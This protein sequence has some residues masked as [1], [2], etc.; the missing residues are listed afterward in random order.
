MKISPFLLSF[1][2]ANYLQAQ[3][4][5]KV[6]QFNLGHLLPSD[7]VSFHIEYPEYERLSRKA[8]E[9]LRNSGFE[10]SKQVKFNINRGISR[11]ETIVDVSYT[12]V[13]KRGGAW[14]VIKQ[15]E[16][17]HTIHDHGIKSYMRPIVRAAY[18]TAKASR[19]AENSVLAT[20]KWVKIRVSK[21]GIYQITDA[22]LKKA[23]FSNP[24]KVKL[25]GYGGRLIN[26]N[27]T[28]TGKNALIDDLN[29]VPLYRR[30]GSLLFYA[31][32]LITW[33]SNTKFTR[34]TF[35]NYSYYFL[36]EAEDDTLPAT[37]QIAEATSAE[38][39]KEVTAV[40]YHAVIDNEAF[41]WYNGGRKFF[42][43]NEL[44]GGHTFKLS[45]PG[46][47]GDECQ[48]SYDLSGLPQGASTPFV[49]YQAN[50]ESQTLASGYFS[51]ISDGESAR[52][53][54]GSF[55]ITIGDEARF[56]VKTEVKGRLNY[57]YATYKRQL[58]PQCSNAFTTDQI[59]QLLLKVEGADSNT[60]IW[61]LGDA[62]STVS[63][64]NG[65]LSGNTYTAFTNDA[66]D[67]YIVVDI[68]A[69][70]DSPTF[71][72]TIENQNLHADQD[73]DY[74]IIVPTSGKLVA[75]AERLA[76]AH[77]EKNGLRVKVVRADQL[78][79]EFSS[80][81]P[82][83][84]AY[85]RYIKMLYDKAS[86]TQNAPRYLLLFGECRYDNRMIT[87]AYKN[88]S[89]D[90]YL[91][92]YER[93]E[94]EKK[95]GEYRLGTLYDYVTDDYYGL[96]DDG[97]GSNVTTEK[98]D[99]GIG[100]FLCK[101]ETQATWLVDQ[102][103][104]YGQNSQVGVWKNRMW[105]VGDAGNNNLHMN[106]A[107]NVSNQ[108][109]LS[110]NEGFM[111]R[112]IYLDAYPVV[113][114]AKGK[115]IP[116]A[117]TKLKTAMQQGALVF[118]YNGHGR[119]ER[120]SNYFL[121]DKSEMETNEST[122][123]PLWIFASC[124]ITPY[125]D[126]TDDL[127]RSAIFNQN[128][129]A[130]G[131]I[132][133]SRSVYANYN[134]SLN[135]GLVKYLFAKDADNKR[136]CI[137]DAMRLAK[138]ELLTSSSNGNTIGSDPTMNKMKYVFLGDPALN[139]AYADTG[140]AIDQIDGNNL[141]STS[142]SNLDVGRTIRFSGHIY[143]SS[144]GSDKTDET[145]NGTLYAT[146]F[147]PQ[148]TITCHGTGNDSASPLQFTDYTQSL[149][150]GN[151]Q[152]KDGRFD[153]DFVIPRGATLSN[154]PSLLSLYAVSND[155]KREYNGKFNR[156]CFNRSSNPEV[157]DT[158][159]P[160]VHM[161]F[162]TPDFPDGGTISQK[163]ILYATIAD[164]SGISVMT[165]NMGHNMDL[166]FDNDQSTLKTVSDYFSL[167]DGKYNEGLLQYEMP[168]LTPGKHKVSL[169]VWDVFDNHTLSVLTFKVSEQPISTFDVSAT[170]S[171]PTS[172][173]QFITTFAERVNP[174]ESTNVITEVFNT[175]GMRVWHQ[176]TQVDAG[177]QYATFTW[178]LTDYAGNHLPSGVYFYRSKVANKYTSTKK[179]IIK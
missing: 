95:T 10:A 131:V 110:A 87:D 50:N 143:D 58:T 57:L 123:M 127:G 22:E 46:N 135:K 120:L 174:Q 12:P 158:L 49:I 30:E 105:A 9:D 154:S 51:K 99:L 177:G 100:R 148:Q 77:R 121:L 112:R 42:D 116:L 72:G 129:G 55:K 164:S 61:K 168:L 56:V 113:S 28:F 94:E 146:I 140:I 71:V 5:H 151:V 115:T 84:S 145:F 26:E 111:L 29:E 81:T 38:N 156:F 161:Y 59:G 40:T 8:V 37:W 91:L 74:V 149:F 60:R 142:I 162:N 35:S 114:E 107:Q 45:L 144:A 89:P 138:V 73:I 80:G 19:Y 83:A 104:R 125:D 24:S 167:S 103:L 109:A 64:L 169:R 67:R 25:Y 63:E 90:D 36:T 141:Q 171:T 160:K 165:G 119:P 33:N 3:D 152:V 126:A 14:Y 54:T 175:A 150:E 136:Y 69:N 75:Q 23:G 6:E 106:D 92:A 76:Q 2:L 101:D 16:L 128:G 17:K 4:L 20:G 139:L 118:N 147:A 11:G 34:N 153:I 78:Y 102:A 31:E 47:T 108:V 15:Y 122:S 41:T 179:L 155:K 166:W 86:D 79:N 178:Q 13:V 66:N 85:R 53:Y 157:A 39:A 98:I 65:T 68:A 173:T 7:S 163:S 130:M 18:A 62:Q 124:E 172:S 117:N 176:S 93:S 82:D 137:G 1:A 133:A 170:N 159:G 48:I 52:G 132:C 88:Q 44:K 43:D 134:S 21:E 27:F 96:L 32:G 70:Y 97:E